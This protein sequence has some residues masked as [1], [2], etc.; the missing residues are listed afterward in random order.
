[1]GDSAT[2]ADGALPARL[3]GAAESPIAGER[4][5]RER[6]RAATQGRYRAAAR[7]EIG[8][9]F[10]ISDESEGLVARKPAV[11]DGQGRADVAE[12]GPAPAAATGNAAVASEGASHGHQCRAVDAGDRPAA[13]NGVGVVV[14]HGLVAGDSHGRERQV[15]VVIED[16]TAQG[17]ASA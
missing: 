8:S 1:V 12:D 17:R 5:G 14:A 7:P 11:A 2:K 15:A 16:T 13:G 6:G 4:N 3:T 9:E 10:I